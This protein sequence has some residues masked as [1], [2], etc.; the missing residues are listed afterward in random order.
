MPEF[1]Y[2]TVVS[3]MED[4][5]YE[6]SQSGGSDV[7]TARHPSLWNV[8]IKLDKA[9]EEIQVVTLFGTESGVSRSNLLEGVNNCNR[10]STI[11]SFRIDGDGNFYVNRCI[12]ASGGFTKTQFN[13][14]IN[15]G[16]KEITTVVQ[17]F[18][19]GLV[20]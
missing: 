14:L 7:V 19:T 9:N 1:N 3:L 6:C 4:L 15:E 8:L 2:S 13:Q 5:G 12:P 16:N 17:K 11:C 20:K 10:H 18:M